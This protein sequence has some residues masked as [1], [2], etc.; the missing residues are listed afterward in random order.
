MI[1]LEGIVMVMHYAAIQP[2]EHALLI[3]QIEWLDLVTCCA[4]SYA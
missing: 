4:L 3:C 1:A 2:L